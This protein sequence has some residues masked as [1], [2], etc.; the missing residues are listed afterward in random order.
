M[1]VI[2]G[3]GKLRQA[4]KDLRVQWAEAKVTWRD[5][6][7]RRF[8]ARYVAPLMARLRTVEL[9][10]GQMGSILQRVRRDCE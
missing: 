8:E 9:T 3:L 1:S 6:N 4:S 10:M 2:A 7:A 5:D